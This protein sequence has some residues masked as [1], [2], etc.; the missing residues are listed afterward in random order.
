[1]GS[2]IYPER[3]EVA[4]ACERKVDF[5]HQLCDFLEFSL[6]GESKF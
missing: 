1:M 2:G 5:V 3:V 6:F 4:H